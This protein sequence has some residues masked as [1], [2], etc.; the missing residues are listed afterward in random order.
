MIKSHDMSRTWMRRALCSLVEDP[1]ERTRDQAELAQWL[2]LVGKLDLHGEQRHDE[3]V[4][5]IVY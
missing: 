4:S 1:L 5:S 2:V 3:G